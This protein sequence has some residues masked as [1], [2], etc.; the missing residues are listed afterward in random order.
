MNEGSSRRI[1]FNRYME[2]RNLNASDSLSISRLFDSM[3]AQYN[4]YTD[5][6]MTSYHVKVQTKYLSQALHILTDMV[7]NS[8]SDPLISK[9]RKKSW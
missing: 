5:Y 6:N 1:S 4:A 9:V 7:A 8:R 3:G 2:T